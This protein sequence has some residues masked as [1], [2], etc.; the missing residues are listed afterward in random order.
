MLSFAKVGNE[1]LSQTALDE[2]HRGGVFF[3][4]VFLRFGM[5]WRTWG[6][7]CILVRPISFEIVK[8]YSLNQ[9]ERIKAR[10][11]KLP[12]WD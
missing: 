2:S 5:K 1:S 4:S 6:R 9:W 8:E 10:K 12:E 11:L 3:F 7:L